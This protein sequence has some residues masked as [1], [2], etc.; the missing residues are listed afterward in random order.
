MS[1][2]RIE[3]SLIKSDAKESDYSKETVIYEQV[4]ESVLDKPLEDIIKAVNK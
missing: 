3:V 1:F 4:F 2:Y